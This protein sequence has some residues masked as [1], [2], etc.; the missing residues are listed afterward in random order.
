MAM[1]TDGAVTKDPQTITRDSKNL[2]PDF[3]VVRADDPYEGLE[4]VRMAFIQHPE[5]SL[6][7]WPDAPLLFDEL[8]Y[9]DAAFAEAGGAAFKQAV[10]QLSQHVQDAMHQIRSRIEQPSSLFINHDDEGNARL[11][12]HFQ[13]ISC[14][15]GRDPSTPSLIGQWHKSVASLSAAMEEVFAVRQMTLSTRFQSAAYDMDGLH[16]DSALRSNNLRVLRVLD[17]PM[18]H[19]YGRED[20]ESYGGLRGY[21]HILRGGAQPWMLKPWDLAF[22]SQ[23]AV[24]QPPGG[25][26]EERRLV[27]VYAIKSAE[28]FVANA[29]RPF[30]RR[31]LRRPRF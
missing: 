10:S 25:A 22:V 6:V 7:V 16:S 29:D 13:K 5:I 15:V 4:D 23:N 8:D 26:D 19:Y 17:G 3:Y 21:E 11:A 14:V 20:V 31:L 27:E 18:T 12:R 9:A 24:H 28:E 1:S 2:P 30:L